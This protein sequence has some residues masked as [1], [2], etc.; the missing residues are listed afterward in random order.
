MGHIV[1]F[2]PE[3]VKGRTVQVI[4]CFGDA[5]AA[6]TADGWECVGIVVPSDEGPQRFIVSRPRA[7]PASRIKATKQELAIAFAEGARACASW[8]KSK[9]VPK[10][11]FDPVEAGEAYAVKRELPEELTR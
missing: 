10:P 2:D 1:T 4:D 6:L 7:F 5:I 8:V 3:M 11:S 9:A